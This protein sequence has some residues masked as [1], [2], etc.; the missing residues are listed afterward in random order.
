MDTL[1]RSLCFSVIYVLEG[2]TLHRKHSPSVSLIRGSTV[3]APSPHRL[4]NNTRGM[5]QSLL[6]VT[7]SQHK[8]K[9]RLRA[10]DLVLFGPPNGGYFSLSLFPLTPMA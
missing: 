2:R 4:A 8:Q 3:T 5:L 7:D 10:M 1:S 9:L 6:G